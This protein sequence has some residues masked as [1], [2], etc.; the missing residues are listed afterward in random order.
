MDYLTDPIDIFDKSEELGLS[1]EQ[2]LHISMMKTID[3]EI[4][5]GTRHFDE[6]GNFLRTAN[7]VLKQLDR[8]ETIVVEVDDSRKQFFLDILGNE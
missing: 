5:L 1:Q 6:K 2:V 3:G 4:K 8:G 7:S